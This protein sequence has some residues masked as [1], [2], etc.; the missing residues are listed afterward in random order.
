LNISG[1][2]NPF[3]TDHHIAWSDICDVKAGT[4]L[5]A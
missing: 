2:F 5:N 3:A 1:A 4:N